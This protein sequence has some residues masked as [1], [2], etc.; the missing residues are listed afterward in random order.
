MVAVLAAVVGGLCAALPSVVPTAVLSL[1]PVCSAGLCC[2]PVYL[3]GSPPPGTELI[4][5]WAVLFAGYFL[6][7]RAAWL[8]VGVIVLGYGATVLG[9]QGAAGLTV[10]LCLGSTS[11]V[12]LLIVSSLRVRLSALVTASRQEARTDGLTGL[13]N[14]RAFDEISAHEMARCQRSGLS[15]AL[16]LIDVDHFKRLN[17]SWGH[18]AG[19]AALR[20]VADVLRTQTRDSDVLARFGGEE[21]AILLPSCVVD[22]AVRRAEHIRSLVERA[23]LA[24]P[25]PLTVSIGAATSPPSARTVVDLVA[26]ADAALYSAKDAGR[27]TVTVLAGVSRP[28]RP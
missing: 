27:N 1:L 12:S 5:V 22:D 3:S 26:A 8:N 2:L 11:V 21:F 28:E 17:D 14:R 19:D 4:L 6:P 20:Q 10:T 9:R 13:L 23:T 7:V 15:L 24:S 16:L 18:L 25:A